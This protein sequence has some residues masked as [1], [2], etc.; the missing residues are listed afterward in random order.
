[1]DGIVLKNDV[2]PDTVIMNKASHY[3]LLF[4]VTKV[5]ALP[6]LNN[7]DAT[8]GMEAERRK[9]LLKMFIHK[10]YRLEI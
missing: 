4:G 9:E 2:P 3:P 5:E 6:E 1:V 7:H 10:Y 8:Y